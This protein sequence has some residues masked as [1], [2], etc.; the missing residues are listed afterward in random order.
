MREMA[1]MIG[2]MMLGK[3]I[4]ELFLGHLY[5]V[6]QR[7]AFG[8]IIRLFYVFKDIHK[9]EFILIKEKQEP[10]AVLLPI[11]EFY[12]LKAIEEHLEDREIARIIEERVKNK[13]HVSQE[14]TL[15]ERF[16]ALREDIYTP[17]Q[18]TDLHE[19]LK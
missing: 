2:S 5:H 16:E 15:H 12:R 11:E 17:A 7:D 6:M 1:L 10:L 19:E 4:K 13:S 18:N 8:F 3:P 9:G 14:A